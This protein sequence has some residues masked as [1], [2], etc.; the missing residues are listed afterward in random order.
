MLDRDLKPAGAVTTTW[1][2]SIGLKK[3]LWEKDTTQGHVFVGHSVE[4]IREIIPCAQIIE[5]L[6]KDL[7]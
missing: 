7:K 2:N 6:V 4:H 5:N 3:A 1:N